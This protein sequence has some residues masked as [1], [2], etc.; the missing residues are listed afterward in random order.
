LLQ[1]P[2]SNAANLD[3]TFRLLL[4]DALASEAMSTLATGVFLTGYAVAL[5]ASNLA[6]GILA[7]A[8]SAVQFLQFPAVVLIE[9]VRRRRAI[10]VWAAGIGRF[11]LILAAASPLLSGPA[12]VIVLITSVA[13]W[14]ASAAVAGC[15]WNSWMR[16]LVPEES[17]GRFFRP[18]CSRKH[19]G[20]HGTRPALWRSRRS[21]EAVAPGLFY[22]CLFSTVS[23]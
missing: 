9:R 20:R 8:P 3:R 14:Q 5:G 13:I 11:F 21:L 7:A 6:I 12:G 2:E 1:S 23:D 22:R 17:Y 15:A 19:G 18:S 16:D 4:Y 10:S